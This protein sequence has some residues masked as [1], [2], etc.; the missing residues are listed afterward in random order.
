MQPEQLFE[1]LSL[2]YSA[3]GLFSFFEF[4]LLPLAFFWRPSFPFAG[5]LVWLSE[6]SQVQYFIVRQATVV[7]LSVNF[8]GI[9]VAWTAL[10]IELASGRP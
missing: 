6:P 3:R 10:L 1:L 5:L 2:L 9:F 8:A 4:S 7:A